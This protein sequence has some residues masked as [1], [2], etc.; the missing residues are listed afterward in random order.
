MPLFAIAHVRHASWLAGAVA[1][2]GFAAALYC[3]GQLSD[4]IVAHMT[5]NGLVAVAVLAFGRWDL[6]A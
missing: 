6:W 1:G 4:A 3:R 5:S 2:T